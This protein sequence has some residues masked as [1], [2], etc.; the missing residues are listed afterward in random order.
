M[1]ENR[2]FGFHGRNGRFTEGV[3][4]HEMK[5]ITSLRFMKLNDYIVSFK[6]PAI[7]ARPFPF[8]Q[9]WEDEALQ[10]PLDHPKN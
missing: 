8:F 5:I 7:A 9:C 2:A 10:M 6:S 3:T 4:R 1:A